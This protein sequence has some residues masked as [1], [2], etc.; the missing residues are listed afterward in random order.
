MILVGFIYQ[1]KGFKEH[2]GI[3]V[4]GTKGKEAHLWDTK[5]LG[6]PSEVLPKQISSD[7]TAWNNAKFGFWLVGFVFFPL[8]L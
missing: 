1:T 4:S 2:K 5:L 3:D 7:Y 6:N 8:T